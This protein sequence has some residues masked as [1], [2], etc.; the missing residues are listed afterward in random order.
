MQGDLQHLLPAK[1]TMLEDAQTA[2][3]CISE[4][5]YHQVCARGFLRGVQ[6]RTNCRNQYFERGL[7]ELKIC[8]GLQIIV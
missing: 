5:R 3:L 2:E 4:G 1:L 7:P 6:G 8:W